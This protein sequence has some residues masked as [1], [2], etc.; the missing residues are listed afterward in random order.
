MLAPIFHEAVSAVEKQFSQA[1]ICSI[2]ILICEIRALS[3]SEFLR[4]C[5]AF[6]CEGTSIDG[7]LARRQKIFMFWME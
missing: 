5:Y 4:T 2:F 7:Y 6:V 1:N 3:F